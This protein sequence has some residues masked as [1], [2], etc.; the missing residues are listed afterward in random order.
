[1]DRFVV[2]LS[3]SA[4]T[5]VTARSAV[6]AVDELRERD[7]G[8]A[9]GTTMTQSDTS[10]SQSP[11]ASAQINQ[12]DAV[13]PAQV[14]SQVLEEM[15][16][17][18]VQNGKQCLHGSA[19]MT[20][21]IAFFCELCSKA[22]DSNVVSAVISSEQL[23]YRAFVVDGYCAWKNATERF[24]VHEASSFHR[25]AVE[26]L[27]AIKKSVNVAAACSAGK[28]KQMKDARTALMKIISSVQFLCKQGLAVRGQTDSDS[29]LTHLLKL[30]S[31]DIPEVKAWL[32]KT[33]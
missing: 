16:D 6:S 26:T 23:T 25:K 2:K 5:N 9:A 27:A 22:K 33:A 30:R 32:E 8:G 18:I 15:L 3:V 12:S 28:L 21:G 4:S 1:M 10:P 20:L 11:S 13:L 17:D 7:V 31:E 24:R 14:L 19:I 29:N